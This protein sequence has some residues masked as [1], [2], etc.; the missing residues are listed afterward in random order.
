MRGSTTNTIANFVL[1]VGTLAALL[2][3]ASYG[4]GE[5]EVN[6]LGALFQGLVVLTPVLFMW[7]LLRGVAEIIEALTELQQAGVVEGGQ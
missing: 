5:Q 6:V 3:F 7:A 4:T 2:S 1:I